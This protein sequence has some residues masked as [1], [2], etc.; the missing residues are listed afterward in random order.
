MRCTEARYRI[1]QTSLEQAPGRADDQ[2]LLRHLQ[3]CDD[4]RAYA[5]LSDSFERILRVAAIDDTVPGPTLDEQ[6]RRVEA[7][8]RNDG[9]VPRRVA[10]PNPLTRP[11]WRLALSGATIALAAFLF[12]PFTRYQTIG[13]DVSVDGTCMEVALNHERMCDMLGNLGLDEAGVDLIG[14]DTTCCVSIL[15]LKTEREAQ[16]VAGA[17]ARLCEKKVTTSIVPIVSRSTGT[18]LER[19]NDLLRNDS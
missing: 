3:E 5:Q 15:D 16:M 14:C 19:A 1:D 9:R 11:A 7:R 17:I 13:Y 4:C 2:D 18:L 10:R 8:L 6:R 12:V